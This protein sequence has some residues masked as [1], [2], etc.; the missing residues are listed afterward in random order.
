M[1]K[2]IDIT[3]GLVKADLLRHF[4]LKMKEARE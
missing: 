3:I 2:E 1:L 4:N